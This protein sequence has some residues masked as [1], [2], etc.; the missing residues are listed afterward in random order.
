M[1]LKTVDISKDTTVKIKDIMQETATKHF[2]V[3]NVETMRAS[4]RAFKNG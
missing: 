4:M 3:T 1:S 2:F